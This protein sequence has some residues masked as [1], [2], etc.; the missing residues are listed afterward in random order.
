MSQALSEVDAMVGSIMDGL[1]Q[2]NLSDIVNIIVV[3]RI[4]A[5]FGL[6]LV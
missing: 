3:V 6:M 5:I 4:F 2:R 1:D